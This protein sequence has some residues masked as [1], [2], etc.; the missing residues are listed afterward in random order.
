MLF[1]EHCV[2]RARAEQARE[3]IG[4]WARKRDAVC[5]AVGVVAFVDDQFALTASPTDHAD[6]APARGP[7]VVRETDPG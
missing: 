4:L 7:E 3:D 1:V 5:G 2:D 6:P